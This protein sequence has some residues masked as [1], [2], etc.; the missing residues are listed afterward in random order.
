ME[1]LADE[2]ELFGLQM[3]ERSGGRLKR[4]TVYVTLGRMQE[5]GYLESRQEPLPEGA[6]GLPRRLYRP[7]G[8][9]MRVLDA[10]R[11]AEQSSFQRPTTSRN[12]EMRSTERLLAVAEWLCGAAVREGVFEPLV[13]DWQ[14]EWHDR[15]VSSWAR[16]R[17]LVSG[18]SALGL[19][20]SQCLL[21]GGLQMPRI[22][23]VKG[24]AVLILS[25]VLLVLIQIGLNTQQ[26]RQDFPFEM[27]IWL[28][29]PLVLPLAVPLAMLP[30]MMLIRGA[31]RTSSRAAAIVVFAG[32]LLTLVTTGW[33][34]PLAWGDVRDSLYKKRS[35]SARRPGSRQAVTVI[36]SRRLAKMR[37]E[38]PEQRAQR[39]EAFRSHPR[40]VAEPG[41]PDTSALE[42]I[43]THDG[44]F[45]ALHS[46]RWAGRSVASDAR[47]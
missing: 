46:A 30:A 21:T 22:A 1:L 47:R 4:G 15:P 10:W 41:Q 8:H 6:I 16:A 32:T 7:T 5:K 33:L 17:I 29:L 39:R 3:V 9:A 44:R 40:Y 42:P 28:A 12:I 43:D 27:R 38:T 31:A 35:N 11:H 18:A 37:N 2:G 23:L 14:R 19:S 45:Q 20:I 36:P 26:F 13:A 24:A 25:T 34:T